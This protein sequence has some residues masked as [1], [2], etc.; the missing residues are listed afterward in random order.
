METASRTIAENTTTGVA[1]GAPV[2]AT[3]P[4][5]GDTPA[6]TLEGADLDSFD[7]DIDRPVADPGR[8]GLRDQVQLHSDL[9]A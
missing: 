9:T 3:D 6:Y 4:D 8:P 5:T 2:T 1:I 7:I